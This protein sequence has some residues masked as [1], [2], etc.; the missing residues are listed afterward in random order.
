MWETVGIR[1]QLGESSLNPVTSLTGNRDPMHVLPWHSPYIPRIHLAHLP[2]LPSSDYVTTQIKGRSPLTSLLFIFFT[3]FALF[4][5]I[6]LPFR[7][8]LAWCDLSGL[9]LRF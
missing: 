1:N 6:N 5:T 2:P 4:P 7:T 3:S 8:V 9:E